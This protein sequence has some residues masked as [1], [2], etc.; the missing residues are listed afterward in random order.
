[1]S[2]NE[3]L[4]SDPHAPRSPDERVHL[5]AQASGTARVHQAG[6]DQ[7]IHYTD[8]VHERRRGGLGQLLD[9]LAEEL[10]LAVRDQWRTEE[11]LRR[12][13]DPAPLLVR[14]SA[15]QETVTDHWQNIQRRSPGQSRMKLDGQLGQVVELFDR[16]PSHRLVVLGKPGAG[17]SVLAMQFTLRWLDRR[18]PGD[19]VPVVFPLASWDPVAQSLHGWMS[20][21]LAAD[22]PALGTRTESGATRAR[23]LVRTR[24]VLPVL[25]G[26]DEIP[27]SLRGD[28][29]RC[30]NAELDADDS[31]LV[32]SRT[33]D[34][35][36]TVGLADVVTSAA[37]VELLPLDIGDVGDNQRFATRPTRGHSGAP[38]TK[39][40]PVLDYLRQHPLSPNATTLAQVLSTPLMA[41]LA[42]QVYSDTDADPGELLDDQFADPA[43]LEGHLLDAFI[44]AAFGPAPRDEDARHRT[45]WNT[46]DAQRWL[47]FLAQHL[48]QLNTRDIAWWRLE[49]ALPAPIRFFSPSILLGIV[50]ISASAIIY[51]VNGYLGFIVLAPAF[52]LGVTASLTVTIKRARPERTPLKSRWYRGELLRRILIVVVIGLIVGLPVGAIQDFMGSVDLE[53]SNAVDLTSLAVDGLVFGVAAGIIFGAAGIVRDPQPSTTSIWSRHRYI[54]VSH[55]FA[56]RFL[57]GL[58]LGFVLSE[59][60]SALLNIRPE[61]IPLFN[62]VI[63]SMNFGY[64]DNLVPDLSLGVVLG[65]LF[66]L[67]TFTTGSVTRSRPPQRSASRRRRR[68]IY[69]LVAGVAVGVVFWLAVGLA[70]GTVAAIR[71]DAKGDDF[72]PGGSY[73]S[74]TDGER[75]VDYPG[76]I[77]FGKLSDGTAYITYGNMTVTIVK[78]PDGQMSVSIAPPSPSVT[79]A[80]TD[81]CLVELTG[82]VTY[83]STCEAIL[84]DRSRILPDGTRLAPNGARIGQLSGCPFADPAWLYE[85]SPDTLLF[86]DLV[87]GIY[88]GLALG[89]V[90]GLA[91]WVYLWLDVPTD[92][93]RAVSPSSSLKAD[94]SA[95]F[96]RSLIVMFLVLIVGAM[97]AM[98][99]G[100]GHTV[101]WAWIPIGLVAM[102]V[103]AWWRLSVAR[104]WLGTGN[105][106]PWRLMGFLHWAH[107]RG[108][109]RQAGAVY[110]FRHARLQERLAQR[111]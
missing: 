70:A 48:D 44:P 2:P 63:N 3:D 66:G 58:T 15:A 61:E 65:L 20:A 27:A 84:P 34:F 74:R 99:V 60:L 59:S 17:K 31:V 107:S 52:I 22:Y 57:I 26:L 32:T 29:V 104:A 1:M 78:D 87:F 101:V 51:L 55:R 14:W 10:A 62:A 39:W 76:A 109:L 91:G 18:R 47:T 13:Q 93:T 19:P 88:F 68:L 12:L 7:H 45:R 105:R 108:V 6:R 4:T 102:S 25:D 110:Q 71:K 33:G 40:D 83:I 9:G 80:A 28:A 90:G 41:S 56:T 85:G 69:G 23:E 67:T 30:L 75:Y 72:P 77:R 97:A 38:I 36:D 50:A 54:S 5:Q 79:C 106:L 95:T 42:R 64:F 46:E 86:N 21:R 92:I 43:T 81:G 111:V 98:G 103:T 89:L 37:V 96:V 100:G 8:G 16:V 11:R 24:R 82:P 73:H 35:E 94:R 53:I 49:T